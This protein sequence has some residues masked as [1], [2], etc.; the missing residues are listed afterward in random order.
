MVEPPFLDLCWRASQ[1]S[2]ASSQ[3]ASSSVHLLYLG[4]IFL[5]PPSGSYGALTWWVMS[6]LNSAGCTTPTGSTAP[7]SASR[8]LFTSRM[9]CVCV[10]SCLANFQAPSG[11]KKTLGEG[12]R[13]TRGNCS[14]SG[15]KLKQQAAMVLD[16]YS[17][18][19]LVLWRSWVSE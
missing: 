15:L 18:L 11:Y 6:K 5:Q 10:P 8:P 17:V 7:A 12:M 16:I 3:R 1:C 14:L 19:W 4:Y 9:H 13:M 2:I